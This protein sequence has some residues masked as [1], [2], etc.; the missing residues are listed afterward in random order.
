MDSGF[1]ITTHSTKL[2]SLISLEPLKKTNYLSYHWT[3]CT[4][5]DG[6]VRPSNSSESNQR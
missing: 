1:K 6:D 2:M 3:S 5:V 4:C